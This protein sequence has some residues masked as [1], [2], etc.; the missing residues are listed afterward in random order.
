MIAA[1][2]QI[3]PLIVIVNDAKQQDLATL[4]RVT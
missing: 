2:A 4:A 3:V 1:M